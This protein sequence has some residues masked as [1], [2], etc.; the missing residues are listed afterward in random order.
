MDIFLIF[1]GKS[2]ISMTQKTPA[3][4]C[5]AIALDF[6]ARKI[7]HQDAG[8][9]IGKSKAVISNQISGKKPFSKAMAELFAK[10]FGYDANFLLYGT[11]ELKASTIEQGAISFDASFEDLDVAVLAAALDVS[12]YLLYLT[13][14]QTAIDAW[15]ALM[16]G[17]YP[18]YKDKVSLL[19]KRNKHNWRAPLV[20]AKYITE[21][22]NKGQFP[23]CC[24]VRSYSKPVIDLEEPQK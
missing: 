14:D 21:R 11:G 17:Q 23:A 24:T 16:N 19:M 22:I 9:A 2:T 10:A 7:T 13:G 8:V 5:E 1:E 6:K 18:I 15:D 12:E 20:M 3:E 4:I